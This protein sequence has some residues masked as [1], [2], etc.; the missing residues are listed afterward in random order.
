MQE[1][2]KNNVILWAVC[3]RGV[4]NSLSYEPKA[5]EPIWTYQE[6]LLI[7]TRTFEPLVNVDIVAFP[8][9]TRGPITVEV[10]SETPADM[11]LS[12][13]TMFGTLL[14]QQ[15][16]PQ[17]AHVRQTVDL[18]GYPAGTYILQISAGHGAW[19]K[20]VVRQ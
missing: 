19:T 8:T 12:V 6:N 20:Q 14:Q 5:Y 16:L 1:V 15:Q 3:F 4:M 13:Y 18:A 17:A 2:A 7:T 10:A 9:T 11:T